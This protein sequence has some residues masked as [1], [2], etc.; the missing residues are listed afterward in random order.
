MSPGSFDVVAAHMIW[1]G[2]QPPRPDHP[3]VS[4]RVWEMMNQC[5]ARVPS[6]RTTIREVVRILQ[7]EHT[8]KLHDTP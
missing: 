2:A 4:D 1:M 8:A 3:E 7:A 6:E 5:W